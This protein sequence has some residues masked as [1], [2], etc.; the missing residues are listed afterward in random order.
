MRILAPVSQPS[1]GLDQDDELRPGRI[2]ILREDGALGFQIAGSIHLDREI[3]PY[4]TQVPRLIDEIR[5]DCKK[6]VV[7]RPGRN[8]LEGITDYKAKAVRI[9]LEPGIQQIVARVVHAETHP[10]PCDVQGRP[11]LVFTMT[12]R[13]GVGA[14]LFGVPARFPSVNLLL[15]GIG[16]IAR[17]PYKLNSI[18]LRGLLKGFERLQGH[19]IHPRIVP[20]GQPVFLIDQSVGRSA[21]NKKKNNIELTQCGSQAITSQV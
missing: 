7:V 6:T 13:G 3:D 2:K 19:G 16:S 11:Q 9:L 4:V 12:W 10:G 18:L 5:D 15:I 14:G 8:R 1:T 21:Q 17:G 20:A